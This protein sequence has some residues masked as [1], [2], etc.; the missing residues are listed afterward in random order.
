MRDNRE[1][2]PGFEQSDEVVRW[3]ARRLGLI[4]AAMNSVFYQPLARP[5]ERSHGN[6]PWLYFNYIY[7]FCFWTP[8]VLVV[9]LLSVWHDGGWWLLLALPVAWRW[10]EIGVW[11]VKLLLDR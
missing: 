7:V 8:V 10:L 2:E 1:S 6:K 11:W 9:A 3:L 5:F 4:Q